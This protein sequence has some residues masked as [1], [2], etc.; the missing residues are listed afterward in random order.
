MFVATR[1]RF[2]PRLPLPFTLMPAEVF[3]GLYPPRAPPR[4]TTC[5]SSSRPSS[6]HPTT[7]TTT[8]PFSPHRPHGPDGAYGAFQRA[9]ERYVERPRRIPCTPRGAGSTSTAGTTV[10]CEDVGCIARHSRAVQRT[11]TRHRVQCSPH[12]PH[13]S[14]LHVVAQCPAS[15][16]RSFSFS[17]SLSLP[18]GVSCSIEIDTI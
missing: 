14:P 3:G 5:R 13:G 8:T 18:T 16:F 1:F 11:N 17:R 4:W 6:P 7:T 15:R 12:P 9:V 2:G 10:G